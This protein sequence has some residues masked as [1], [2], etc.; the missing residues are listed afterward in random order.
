M[1]KQA[2]DNLVPGGY[3]E[4]HDGVFPMEYLGEPPVNSAL[5]QWN[6]LLVEAAARAG[7][8]WTNTPFYKQW[9]EETGF[10]DIVVRKFF[11]PMSPWA[12]GQYYKTIAMYAQ[13]DFGGNIEGISLKLFG[14]LG[15]DAERI[16]KFAKDVQ[17][18]IHDTSIHAYLPM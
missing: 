3:L 14:F 1:I 12:K 10:E 5:Y 4:L 8:P 16:K 15:W 2:Y 7:R 13:E 9:M 17:R 18:D 6:D 11:W